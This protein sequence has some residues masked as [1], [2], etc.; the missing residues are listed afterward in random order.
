MLRSIR[1]IA[2]AA[3]AASPIVG[4]PF[5]AAAAQPAGNAEAGAAKAAS[6]L[7]C[8]GVNGNSA[9]PE[10]PSVAGQNAAYIAEQLRMFRDGKRVNVLM[11]PMASM[12]TDEDIADIGAY[13]ASQT[14][15]GLEA[16]PSYWQA[17]EALYRAGD[18]TRNI[19]ACKACHGPAGRGNPAAGYPALRAQ[20][21]VYTIKQLNDYASEARYTDANGQKHSSRNGH[22][23]VTIAKRLTEEDIRNLASY[24]QGMR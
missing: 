4:G 2:L 8:H 24:I 11:S 10:W 21:S 5:A 16:D 14:P 7:A 3:V 23:M 13:Y 1:S 12:L 18:R 22:M 15:E 19:P 9:N 20:H 17:G 6:C